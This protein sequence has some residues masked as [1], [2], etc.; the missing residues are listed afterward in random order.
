MNEQDRNLW[1]RELVEE[2]V[3]LVTAALAQGRAGP[4]Q[5]QAA[6]A[7]V[8]DEA[9]NAEATDWGRVVGLHDALLK[10][11]DN[12]IVALNRAVAV[13]VVHGPRAGLALLA[14]LE[15]DP[16]VNNDRR[17]H[18]AR[19]HFLEL[20]GQPDAALVAYQAAVDRA[21]SLQHQRYLNSQ[22]ARLRGLS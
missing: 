13:S 3:A 21:T 9:E 5:L 10:L 12:P 6:I 7:A 20:N 19:A 15:A 2:G 17:F 18:A 1:D 22:I 11:E 14:E 4:Y 8:H 16:R